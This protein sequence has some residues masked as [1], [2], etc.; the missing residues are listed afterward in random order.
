V[1][2]LKYLE[3]GIGNAWWLRTETEFADG[4]ESEQKG[5]VRPIK[6]KSLYFRLWLGKSVL[7]LDTKEGF[8][9]MKKESKKLKII[10]G[11][12]SL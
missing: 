11:I 10:I 6:V 4:T 5:I 7:I 1:R 2:H 9:K 8:K 12:R 3:F